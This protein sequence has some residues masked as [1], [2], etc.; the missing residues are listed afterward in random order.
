[1]R[2]YNNQLSYCTNIHPYTN[3]QELIETIKTHVKTV[4]GNFSQPSAAGLHLNHRLVEEL[5][6]SPTNLTL[7]KQTL[8]QNQ[9]YVCSLNCFPY[10]E[11]HNQPVKEKVYYPDWGSQARVAYTIKAAEILQNLLPEN[12]EGSISTVPIT[13]GKAIP[14]HTFT[15]LKKVTRYLH[16]LPSK[17]TLALEPEPDCYLDT[18]ADTIAFFTELKTILSPEEFK[19]VGLCFDTCHFA[20]GFEDVSQAFRQIQNADIPIP[21]VQ[22]SAALKTF[23][24]QALQQFVEPV[25]LHQTAI[26]DANGRIKCYKD[27]TADLLRQSSQNRELEWRVHFHVPI[28]QHDLGDGLASTADCLPDFLRLLK[29]MSNIHVELETYSF[30]VIKEVKES[31]T[32]SIINELNYILEV[33]ND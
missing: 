30:S 6:G 22:I 14:E 5:T 11:F 29:K 12:L 33:S 10:G 3:L 25:Y 26:R 32:D 1:M 16:S 2:F 8:E 20:V 27:L 13:Y 23:N 24:P 17:I 31:V 7:L 19:H 4:A 15:N 18:T 21:K 9:L 28:H